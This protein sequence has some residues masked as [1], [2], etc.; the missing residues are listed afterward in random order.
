MVRARARTRV[1]V[2]AKAQTSETYLLVAAE[3][4]QAVR[5]LQ[6]LE[7][8][9]SCARFGVNVFLQRLE[10]TRVFAVAYDVEKERL[11]GCVDL[12]LEHLFLDAL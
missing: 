5:F 1:S 12:A 11:S 3:C 7:H 10:H 9:S 2:R 8:G 4:R 6:H